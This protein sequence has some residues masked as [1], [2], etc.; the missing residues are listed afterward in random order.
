MDRSTDQVECKCRPHHRLRLWD[1]PLWCLSSTV[2]PLQETADQ[3]PPPLCT[4]WTDLHSQPIT[5]ST[6]QKC[7]SQLRWVTTCWL[8]L[9]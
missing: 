5:T 6:A 3:C 1:P 2:L 4:A 7:A 9:S 8:M